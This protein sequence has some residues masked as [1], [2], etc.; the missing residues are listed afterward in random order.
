MSNIRK[1]AIPDRGVCYRLPKQRHC[2]QNASPR[3][4][5]WGLALQ[6]AVES[7]YRV[8]SVVRSLEAGGFHRIA[9]GLEGWSKHT[10][11]NGGGDRH[12]PNL[13]QAHQKQFS[14][15]NHRKHH[16]CAPVRDPSP[17]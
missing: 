3:V 11:G 6:E 15:T 4:I 5:R 7:R 10:V 16:T 14:K 8:E 9:A 12:E 2:V 1:V 17:C 13:R